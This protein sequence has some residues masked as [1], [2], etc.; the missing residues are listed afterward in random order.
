VGC[1]VVGSLFVISYHKFTELPFETFS[2]VNF[3][4]VL[5]SSLG[6]LDYSFGAMWCWLTDD[7][8]LHSVCVANMVQGIHS[9]FV[10]VVWNDETWNCKCLWNRSM[11]AWQAGQWA[12]KFWSLGFDSHL[13][14]FSFIDNVAYKVW[15]FAMLCQGSIFAYCVQCIDDWVSFFLVRDELKL[16]QFA[17]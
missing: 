17:F 16:G 9:V 8:T 4:L 5:F 1:N 7:K 14:Q 6:L 15:R 10:E 2:C 3:I 11:S 13:L 12:L